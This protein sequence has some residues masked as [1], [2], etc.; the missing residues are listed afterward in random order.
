M[1]KRRTFAAMAACVA[2]AALAAPAIA[3]DYGTERLNYTIAFGPGGGNDRM[4]R[5]VVDI[6]RTYDLYPGNIVVENRE[7]GS[8]AVGFSFVAN[9]AGDPYRL[10]STSGN[11]I[12]TPL[13]S[14][15]DWTYADFTPI[16]LLASDAMLLVVRSDSGYE[17]VDAF[18]EAANAGRVTIAGSGS[19]GPERVTAELFAQAADIEFEYVPIG[20][21]GELVTALTSGS[22]DAVVANPSEV[23]GQLEAGTLVALAFSDTARST[24][25]PDVPTFMELGYD[26]SFSLPRGVVMP[27][28]V[29]A[30]V[31]DWWIETLQQVV[32]TPEWQEYLVTNGMSG[33]PIWGDDFGAYLAETS[34][35]YH[36]TLV[37]IGAIEE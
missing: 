2:A 14:D 31:Q 7:G 8:G 36:E 6:L 25:N 11:F 19:A 21:G 13:V 12:G 10:T 29:D 37:S 26:F 5:T 15:T 22:V 28:G 3:D 35:R 18:V 9:N 33:N 34:A 1:I 32:E 4:S 23:G 24:N 17:S 27:G 16:G 20:S 30:E